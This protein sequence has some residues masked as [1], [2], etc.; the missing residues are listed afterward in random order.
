MTDISSVFSL[1]MEPDIVMKRR[2]RE[3]EG[4]EKIEEKEGE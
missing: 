4:N 3:E 2:R 1:R